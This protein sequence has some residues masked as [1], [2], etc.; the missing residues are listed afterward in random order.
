MENMFFKST[1]KQATG[2]LLFVGALCSLIVVGP[3]NSIAQV[4]P[5][6]DFGAIG[7]GQM[8]KRL[9]TA[10]SVMQIGAHPDDEDSALLAYLAR[11]ESA[12]T[13]YLSLTRGDG[14]Q[15]ILGPEL[16]EAL[17]VIR[18]EELLQARRLDGA[19]QFFTRASDFGFS[20]TLDE[21]KQKWP[22]QIILCDVVRAIRIFQPLVVISRFSGTPA[23]NHGQHQY[24]GFIAPLAVKA[25]GDREQCRDAGEPWQVHKFY[26]G[27]GFRSN[28]EPDVR[29]NTG[30]YDAL[31][32]RSYFEIAMEGRSQHKS[33]EQG[34]LELRGDQFSGLNLVESKLPKGG[35]E[36]SVFDGIDVSISG[37]AY[38]SGDTGELLP[39][40]L[41]KLKEFAA[42]A[43]SD[44]D[45]V[46]PEKI[47][48][49][50]VEGYELANDLERSTRNPLAKA[51]LQQ[52]KREFADAF[53]AA[54]GIR[55]DALSN[56]DT[57]VP[58]ETLQITAKVFFPPSA[59]VSV[60]EISLKAPQKWELEKT[61]E[62]T[63]TS[64][65]FFR[66][67]TGNSEAFFRVKPPRDAMATQPYWLENPRDGELYRWEAG[68]GNATLPFQ[69]PL[70]T[71]EAK[72]DVA[73]VE[74]TLQQP[75]QYRYAD[76]I[77]GE[78]RRDLNLVPSLTIKV[79]Q[80]M[81]IVPRSDKAQTR[82][83]VVT[84][85]NHA[86]SPEFAMA[87]LNVHTA[88]E[89]PVSTAD[90]SLIFTKKGEKRSIAFDV[91]IP[92][93][94]PPGTYGISAQ[95][96]LKDGIAGQEMRVLAYP[97]IQT[98]RYYTRAR[99]E[100][101][102]LELKAAPVKVG[103]IMGSGDQ[104][105]DAI[106]QMGLPVD[107]LDDLNSADLT[108][109]DVVV[110]GIRV[111][112]VRPDFI[113]HNNKLLDYVKAGGTLIVQYQRPNYSQQKLMPYPAQ[114]GPRVVDENAKVTVLQ[115]EHPIFNFPNKIT[116]DDFSGWVQERNLYNF[117]TFDETYTP[118]LEAHDAGE[119]ENKGGLVIADFGKGK[120]I[121]CS[122]SLF[123]QL[124]SGVGGAYRLFANMLS[125]P[126]AKK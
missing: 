51:L 56:M 31:L 68:D 86:Q 96:G 95:A 45:P 34:L 4:R 98:H 46:A 81:L 77:R 58:G 11:G 109:Y 85:E 20:K 52:K 9:N 122:Y 24:S 66:R 63:G 116:N 97:H 108:R 17:G 5:V 42:K 94:T 18:T 87:G 124:P 111:S 89:W 123:R 44:F 27:Q 33:Q 121:Y 84:V 29:L 105:P 72:M 80:K 54:A 83:V 115:P 21:A 49:L 38:L 107:L 8:L 75:V 37:I 50:L 120:Y 125:L 92:A 112:E 60:K 43:A 126:K 30:K 47:V 88:P 57:A 55:L 114:M 76:D 13:A 23:D 10:A 39:P 99:I 19:Q 28:A 7:L 70:L 103:Y 117:S 104:V 64:Q 48:P 32:G 100:V 102:V 61:T 101:H 62:P 93:K 113:A 36:T 12:R 73:G 15:N 40:K 106:K 71:A 69:A 3:R 90:R 41:A 1:L 2:M 25:A 26:R 6:Y 79:D 118:L 53:K 59:N 22:E 65:G 74:I 82:R 119:P 67:E 14:G 35:R 16:F 78:V 110:A 91:T